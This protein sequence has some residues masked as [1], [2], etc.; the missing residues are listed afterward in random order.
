LSA[1]PKGAGLVGEVSVPAV[2]DDDVVVVGE[3]PALTVSA[4]LPA[5][6]GEA[7]GR[8]RLAAG[9]DPNLGV[10][11]QAADQADLVQVGD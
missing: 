10:A 3:L 8:D 2:P 6:G 7:E 1:L 11:G 4:T 9:G 5:V